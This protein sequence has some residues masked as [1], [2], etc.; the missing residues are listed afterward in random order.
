M[1]L[2]MIV[3]ESENDLKG[4]NSPIKQGEFDLIID[5]LLIPSWK[6]KTPRM[7]K[8]MRICLLRS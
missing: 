4:K 8:M 7:K 3:S 5:A 1:N 2:A 6:T